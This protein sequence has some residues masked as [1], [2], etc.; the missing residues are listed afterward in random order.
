MMPQEPSE[1][2]Q[3]AAEV[4]GRTSR[5]VDVRTDALGNRLE[6]VEQHMIKLEGN[7][8]QMLQLMV[9]LQQN[10]QQLAERMDRLEQ[11]Q[12]MRQFQQLM[13]ETFKA[14]GT[15]IQKQIADGFA[16]LAEQIN[17][18]AARVDRLERRDAADAQ[19]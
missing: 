10:Q 15:D 14:F 2:Q 11:Q 18:L 17:F 1:R 5:Y 7:Q 13:L 4:Y 12:E 6:V 9:Q 3:I 8:Q 16:A 19:E